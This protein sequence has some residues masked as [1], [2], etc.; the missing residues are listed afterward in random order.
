MQ[1]YDQV[2]TCLI[3]HTNLYELLLNLMDLCSYHCSVYGRGRNLDKAVEMFNMAQSKGMTLDEK[4]Y[5][6]MIVYLGKAGN[7]N[8]IIPLF[9]LNFEY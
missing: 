6:N 5:T 9:E 8:I 1:H 3:F 2:R 7:K 4:A